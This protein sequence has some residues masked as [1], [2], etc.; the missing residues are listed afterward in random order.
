MPKTKKTHNVSNSTVLYRS[1]TNKVFG[2]VCGG[3]GEVFQV[4]PTL[5]RILFV[6]AFLMGGTGILLYLILWLVIPSQSKIM[7][8][9]N[10][11]FK[12][13][14]E[15]MKTRAQNFTQDIQGNANGSRAGFGAV[16]VILGLMFLLNNYG[17]THLFNFSRLWP[18]LLIVFGFFIITRKDKP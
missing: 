5:L 4:D 11:N 7:H 16:I 6:I 17:Y 8:S 12:E 10:E 18:V 9:S 2:G 14:I 13:N 3:L 15:E 1:E